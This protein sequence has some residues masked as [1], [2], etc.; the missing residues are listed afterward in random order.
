MPQDMPLPF[1]QNVIKQKVP[2][3]GRVATVHLYSTSLRGHMQTFIT[4]KTLSVEC[5][6]SI[7]YICPFS[8]TG[9]AKLSVSFLFYIFLLSN[10]WDPKN[11]ILL[12]NV[13]FCLHVSIVLCGFIIAFPIVY[14]HCI[15][16]LCVL[17]SAFE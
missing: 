6:A 16:S 3:S 13:I 4:V 12:S 2:V 10:M 15:I 11:K 5:R 9:F 14:I 17:L 8:I 7:L 1:G